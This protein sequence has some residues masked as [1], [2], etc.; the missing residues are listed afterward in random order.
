MSKPRPSLWSEPSA[1]SRYAIA[2]LSVA[3][4]I[5]VAEI[6]TRW[7]HT[8]PIASSMLC[9]VIFAA[10]FGFGPGLLAIALS[11]FAFHYY[12]VPPINSFALKHDIFAVDVAELPRLALFSITSLFVNFISWAERSAKEAALQ[13]KA[14]AARAEREI[15]LVADTIPAL[16]W[17]ALPDGAVEYFNQRWLTYTGLTLEQARGWGF[18]DAYHPEDRTSVRNLTSVGIP[19]AASANDRTTEARLRGVDGKYRWFLGRAMALRDEAGNIVRW[20]GTAVDIED[21][22]RVEDAL[23]RSEAYLAEAQRLSATGTFGWKVASDD[24][25]W[26]EETYRIFGID[27]ADKPTIALV[28]QRVHPDDRELVRHELDRVAEGSH[29]FDV[30]H[31]LLMPDGLVKYLHVRSHRV[32]CE[33]G[34][35]EIVGAVM[36]VT[37]ARDAQEALHAAQAELAHVNRVTTMGQLTASIAHEINQPIT[38]V[39]T[40]ASA[41]LLWLAAQPP[42]LEEVRDAFD[43]VI[44]AGHQAGKVTGRIRDLIGKAPPRKGDVEINEAILEVV[45]LTH[46]EL[47]KNGVSLRTRLAAGLPLVQGDKVQ[48]QQVILNLIVNAVEAMSG[49]SEGSRELLIGTGRDAS[50]GLVVAVQDSG[51]GLNP[52]S[53]DRLFDPFYTTKPGGMGMGLSICRSI[54]EA[55]GGR[56]WAS[57]TSGPGVTVQF[58]LPVGESAQHEATR[59]GLG[60][61]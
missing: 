39:V 13:A 12:L 59:V 49:V 56:V 42:N 33:S 45:A 30:E 52:E 60:A 25:V 8:E 54:V 23:R 48:L 31:R 43:R 4:A 51:P 16:V 22:K 58:T 5:V 3:M 41:G 38:A 24:V 44:K 19:H 35:E 55:H 7:L 21:R 50:S 10:W 1:V 37:A 15:R 34:D 20:Y 6:L 14:K 40:D 2:A 46:G 61:S 27:R 26:S 57:R 53:F 36:D 32:K 9:A 17:S 47:V 28:L 18:I 29:D 11:L